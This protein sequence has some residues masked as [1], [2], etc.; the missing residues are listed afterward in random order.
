[1]KL[2]IHSLKG[3]LFDGDAKRLTLPTE[4]GEITILDEHE[5]LIA[6]TKSGTAIVEDD[7]KKERF[8]EINS[9]FLEVK[10]TNEVLVLAD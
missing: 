9:G 1:M 5:P 8:F 4:A 6:M 2:K 3:V 10:D 7:E